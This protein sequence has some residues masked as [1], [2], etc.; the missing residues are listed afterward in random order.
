MPLSGGERHD[1]ANSRKRQI[2]VV[3]RNAPPCLDTMHLLRSALAAAL[4]TALSFFS[5]APCRAAPFTYDDAPALSHPVARLAEPLSGVWT[6]DYW[7]ARLRGAHTHG[8]FRPLATLSFALSARAGGDAP[9]FRAV[10]FVL[11]AL[12]SILVAWLA[13]R[14]TRSTA[15]ALAAGV[16]F[17]IHPAL[18]EP[19]CAVALRAD[20]LAGVAALVCVDAFTFAV[21]RS[22]TAVGCAAALAAALV[23]AAVGT[24]CKE[25]AL[26]AVLVCAAYA[27]AVF[28]S[29]RIFWDPDLVDASI[30]C[31]CARL[32]ATPAARDAGAHRR[33]PFT[34]A[35]TRAPVA[36]AVVGAGG[37]A[38]FVVRRWF[39]ASALPVFSAFENIS[40]GLEPGARAMTR[41]YLFA[42]HLSLLCF[43]APLGVDWSGFAVAP[44]VSIFDAR[45]GLTVGVAAT[46]VV[47]SMG[48]AR[49]FAQWE[50]DAFAELE[51]VEEAEAFAGRQLQAASSSDTAADDRTPPALRK[52]ET[53]EEDCLPPLLL[54]APMGVFFSLAWVVLAF[55]PASGIFFDVGFT[56]AERVLYFPAMGFSL[57]VAYQVAMADASLRKWGETHARTGPSARFGIAGLLVAFA[58][59]TAQRTR[60][61]SEAWNSDAALWR[62]VLAAA[63][64][65]PKALHSLGVDAARRGN[66]TSALEYYRAAQGAFEEFV[67]SRAHPTLRPW[68]A[69]YPDPYI[70]EAQLLV[71]VDD[72]TDAKRA[73]IGLYSR[74]LAP[75]AW[76][77]ASD[78]SNASSFARTRAREGVHPSPPAAAVARLAETCALA[79]GTDAAEESPLDWSAAT[80]CA[81]TSSALSLPAPFVRIHERL[82]L[83]SAASFNIAVL[84][85]EI[86]EGAS[87]VARASAS[88]ANS[89]SVIDGAA[90]AF[91]RSS[92]LLLRADAEAIPPQLPSKW[93]ARALDWGMFA[94]SVRWVEAD[95]R[96]SLKRARAA[97]FDARAAAL[98]AAFH[99]IARGVRVQLEWREGGAADVLT[100][101]RVRLS[102]AAL[103]AA[104]SEPAT[105]VSLPATAAAA[106]RAAV[107][108]HTT[109][110]SSAPPFCT[111]VP[112][113][114]GA[115]ALGRTVS[116]RVRAADAALAPPAAT[117]F[118]CDAPANASTPCGALLRSAASVA[119][120]AVS[121]FK[122]ARARGRFAGDAAC[123]CSRD[124]AGAL[125]VCARPTMALPDAPRADGL[126]DLAPRAFLRAASAVNDSCAAFACARWPADGLE[127]RA[128]DGGSLADFGTVDIDRLT[129]PQAFHYARRAEALA[130]AWATGPDADVAR[131]AGGGPMVALLSLCGCAEFL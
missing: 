2:R 25:T 127:P 62:G 76:S 91:L 88:A 26:A 66:V 23:A 51:R 83:F 13:S 1:R 4:L 118:A 96:W 49:K 79:D 37:A 60:V 8:S 92:A 100:T 86:E 63:P 84:T 131:T 9:A 93:A 116:E 21:A 117:P 24:L 42:R 120:A 3:L 73:A 69:L 52:V 68:D 46:V 82:V 130:R 17:A 97:P 57:L 95:I 129:L 15:A 122:E 43:P 11:H 103:A 56:V 106:V 28:A 27:A 10:N 113:A 20:V 119:D 31:G 99:D 55:L 104:L 123:S 40:I 32:S 18:A 124:A 30:L 74:L 41:A 33:N 65:A 47:I 80:A 6:R 39:A 90:S 81:H 67:S 50:D 44:V 109:P 45:N 85:A 110:T 72:S 48:A 94:L 121:A 98:D 71:Q 36:A 107:R 59:T 128:A 29:A 108:L 38:I 111:L 19:V 34:L 35:A 77:R 70:N 126:R 7:G 115:R 58:A 12:A 101:E 89:S 16:T 61:V 22:R 54:P 105:P 125:R 102:A 112:H 53:E 64:R 78:T 87:F 75:V 5:H 14:A 114:T